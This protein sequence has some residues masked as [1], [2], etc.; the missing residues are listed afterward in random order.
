MSDSP[1]STLQETA[2]MKVAVSLHNDREIRQW[3][4]FAPREVATAEWHDLI[5][6]KISELSLPTLLHKRMFEVASPVCLFMVQLHA[7]H[8]EISSMF[9]RPC[10][11]LNGILESSV[12]RTSDGLF[13][14]M[15]T[16]ERL[17]E[18]HRI[19][20]AFRFTMACEFQ[21]DKC[22]G[23][24][25]EQLTF[26]IKLRFSQENMLDRQKFTFRIINFGPSVFVLVRRPLRS[27][28]PV[29]ANLLLKLTE[30]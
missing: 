13:D 16:V 17:V 22:I 21:L 4:K 28:E 15:K 19:D 9:G 1:I 2:A 29:L 23:P 26:D 12:F 10:Q 18:N 5:T 14:V 25:F 27:H 24:L 30:K 7:V 3:S 6:S 11:C 20:M 8:S